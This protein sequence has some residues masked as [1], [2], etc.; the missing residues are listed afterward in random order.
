MERILDGA[1]VTITTSRAALLAPGIAI[2]AGLLTLIPPFAIGTG[3]S[4]LTLQSLEHWMLGSPDTFEALHIHWL[5]IPRLIAFVTQDAF[6]AL[7]IFR[8]VVV[9][10]SVFFFFKTALRLFDQRRAMIGSAMLV[11]NVT[12]LFLL[13]T[14]DTQL[15]TLLAASALLYLFTSQNPQ[16]HKLGAIIFGLSLSIGFWPFIL[17]ISVVTV[18]L[19]LHHSVYELCILYYSRHLLFR[20]GACLVSNESQIFSA[21]R[22]KPD[23]TGHY[24]CGL[25]DEFPAHHD[26]PA[27]ERR[28]RAGVPI[29]IRDPCSVLSHEYFFA[30]RDAARCGNYRTVPDSNIFR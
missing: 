9:A 18:G 1:E 25:F 20:L 23:R 16:Y 28:D 8:A 27:K 14:F 2:V 3:S 11:L 17:L 19:N 21:A 7:I 5:W 15:L 22:D 26:I 12:I 10:L 13:H 4:A 6:S 30:R 29:G 24:H